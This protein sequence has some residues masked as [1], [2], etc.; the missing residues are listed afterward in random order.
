[1]IAPLAAMQTKDVAFMITLAGVGVRGSELL[2]QQNDDVLKQTGVGEEYRKYFRELN[3]RVYDKI[4][5]MMPKDDVSD[6]LS[7]IFDQWKATLPEGRL[8]QMG[9][10]GEIG[11]KKF[12]QTYKPLTS[13]WFRYFLAYDPQPIL[14][15]IKIPVL[16][17]N[18]SKDAQVAAQANLK[19]FEKGLLAARK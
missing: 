9:F 16:A 6:S 18:G 13:P 14:S 7:S 1:M 8:G 3:Q 4:A 5:T 12:L 10:A 19:G 2:L 15:R 17:L 11:K